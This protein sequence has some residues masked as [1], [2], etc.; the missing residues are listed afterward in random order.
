MSIG[1]KIRELR[2]EH[3]LLQRELAKEIHIAPNT[4]S[5]FETGQAN[6][7][8][9][10]L[11]LIADFFQ[12]STDYLLGREDDF[13]N[14]VVQTEKP[15]PLPQDEQ[16]LL[17]IYQSLSPAYRSQVLEYARYFAEKSG[18]ATRRKA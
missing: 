17:Q 8:Y 10:V 11:S 3:N 18:A 12:C 16:E 13:G 1:K 6:P 2:L 14:V 5:Q 7:S 9:E 4:L 15:A